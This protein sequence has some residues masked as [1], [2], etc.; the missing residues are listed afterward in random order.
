MLVA[1]GGVAGAQVEPVAYNYGSPYP[2]AGVYDPVEYVVTPQVA[3]RIG[4]ILG[5]INNPQRRSEVAQQWLQFSKQAIARDQEFRKEW[6]EVQKQ[7]LRQ[8][9]QAQQFQLEVA[10]LQIRIEELRAENLRLEQENLQLR[11]AQR[12]GTGTQGTAQLP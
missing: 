12:P 4:E 1:T 8:Q 5:A 10:Q 3:D 6:L 2:A 9:Q 11:Q 7:Q